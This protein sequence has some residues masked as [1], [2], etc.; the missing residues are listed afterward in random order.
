[1]SDEPRVDDL[2]APLRADPPAGRPPAI[3]RDRVLARMAAAA[4]SAPLERSRRTK[5][6]VAYAMAA[7]LAATLGLA[8][9]RSLSKR[10]DAARILELTAVSGYV[11]LDTGMSHSITAGQSIHTT[12][13]GAITTGPGSSAHIRANSG[14]EVDVLEDTALALD[15]LDPRAGALHLYGGAIRCQVPRLPTGQ[16]FSVVTPE[17]TVI[18]H[19]T[20]FSIDVRP[21]GPFSHGRS[22]FGKRTTVKVDEGVVVVRY[23]SG[24]V[25]LTASQSWTNPPLD[26]APEPEPSSAAPS[27]EPAP[28][29]SAAPRPTPRRTTSAPAPELGTLDEETRLLRSGL[30]AERSGDLARAAASFEQLLARYPDSPLVPDAKAALGRVRARRAP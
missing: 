14:V 6:L 28:K 20:V 19:G 26:S 9:V 8:G 4:K 13:E 30:A 22:G 16:T 21:R 3:D 10:G 23:P 11:A 2:L 24:E 27:G 7:V 25:T 29:S 17:A 18:V 1:M 12:A 5:R 15:G